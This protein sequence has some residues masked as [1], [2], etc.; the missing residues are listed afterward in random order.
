MG[1][2]APSILCIYRL[3]LNRGGETEHREYLFFKKDIL[4]CNACL[5][6]SLSA[7]ELNSCYRHESRQLTPLYAV[8]LLKAWFP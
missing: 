1:I 2:S 6:A 7:Q 8:A 4:L 5:T 3:G